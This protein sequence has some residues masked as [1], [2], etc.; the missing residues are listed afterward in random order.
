MAALARDMDWSKATSRIEEGLRTRSRG[1]RDVGH[2]EHLAVHRPS[3][4]CFE[5]FHRN[6]LAYLKISNHVTKAFVHDVK[7]LGDRFEITLDDNKLVYAERVVF[8]GGSH[9]PNIPSSMQHIVGN[10]RVIHSEKLCM[11]KS[12]WTH[13]EGIRDGSDAVVIGGGLTA[14]HVAINLTMRRLCQS[15]P[16]DNVDGK[17]NMQTP[18]LSHERVNSRRAPRSRRRHRTPAMCTGWHTTVSYNNISNL[19]L[20]SCSSWSTKDV[21]SSSTEPTE[22][23]TLDA[24]INPENLHKARFPMQQCSNS[25]LPVLSHLSTILKQ[26]R[27]GS[28]KVH[29]VIRKTLRVRPFD[30]DA[31]WFS[32]FAAQRQLSEFLQLDFDDRLTTLG[33]LRGGSIPHDIV[34][35][36]AVLVQGG[37]LVIHEQTE[38]IEC[39]ENLSSMQKGEL[40]K[41]TSIPVTL[42]NGKKLKAGILVLCTGTET[43]VCKTPCLKRMQE[44]FPI[45]CKGGLPCLEPSLRW[46][47]D[48]PLYIMGPLAALQVGPFAR[49]IRGGKR[50]ASVIAEDII[51]T[52]DID[53]GAAPQDANDI[54][55]KGRK[56][57]KGALKTTDQYIH[58]AATRNPFSLLELC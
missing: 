9:V 47:T 32:R 50:A 11:C 48:I 37:H 14:A 19:P 5:I 44:E 35:R 52:I 3:S 24:A 56:Q 41:D 17:A 27:I 4:L 57:K 58:V 33:E 21:T 40:Q 12:P 28:G 23:T 16:S 30:L 26:P 55:I 13:L 7:W 39:N 38:V 18:S 1:K 43:D 54:T 20:S 49:N 8:A 45:K 36:L 10:S 34:A 15:H 53:E 2:E 6:L 42:S 31:A 22:A 29:L 46:R 51:Q 25:G